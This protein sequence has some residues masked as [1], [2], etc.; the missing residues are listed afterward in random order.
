MKKYDNYK[1]SG[2]EW[3]G[4]VPEHWKL[5]RVKDLSLYTKG[6]NPNDL[7]FEKKEGS[8]PYLSMEYLRGVIKFVL[9]AD[10]ED[11][12]VVVDDDE[13]LLLWD[14]SN[15]GEFI[16]SKKGILASTCA[17]LNKIANFQKQWYYYYLKSSEPHLKGMTKGM[18]IP[19]VDGDLFRS[20]EL[21]LP[22]FDEQTTIAKYLDEKTAN[23]DRRIELIKQKIEKYKELRRSLISQ[24]VTRGLNPN[25]KLKPSGIE[26]LGDIPEH[27][28]IKRVKEIGTVV[29][30]ATPK[31]IEQNWDGNINWISPADM[32]DFGEISKGERTLTEK[33]YNSCGT[34]L[35]PQGTIVMSTR[36]PIGK[37]NIAVK[38]LCTNQGCKCVVSNTIHSRFL[39]YLLWSNNTKFQALGRGTT[40]FEL[41]TRDLSLFK[42]FIPPLDEQ[43]AIAKYLDE[44]TAQIDKI[45]EKSE[46]QIEQLIEL[47]KTLIA[48]VVTGKIKVTD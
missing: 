39:L 18:G 7:V 14:G 9:Y 16:K 46:K 6:K 28:K 19:H 24:V 5:R 30:G 36:A 15:A 34:T 33:G 8:L 42:L 1:P 43:T 25:V 32:D 10:V 31:D 11:S 4:E 20:F 22:P 12:L 41:S 35:V 38:E 21:F 40:F 45:V 3:L 17:V 37:T 27:W 48:Q 13:I 23:I 26:W 47:R 29:C 2:I 44:K